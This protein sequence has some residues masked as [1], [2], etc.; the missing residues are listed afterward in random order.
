[1]GNVTYYE[2]LQSGEFSDVTIICR[3]HTWKAHRMVLSA[4]SLWFKKACSGHF[5][6]A[7]ER[8]IT[9][10][11]D[12]PELI[13]SMIKFIYTGERHFE[14][15]SFLDYFEM[16]RLGDY[17]SIDALVQ[18][19]IRGVKEDMDARAQ[20]FKIL[21]AK[22]AEWAIMSGEITEQF[23]RQFINKADRFV[24]L[25]QVSFPFFEANSAD[26]FLQTLLGVCQTHAS[27]LG[28]NEQFRLMLSNEE[29]MGGFARQFFLTL[30]DR[31]ASSDLWMA[32][33][34]MCSAC[35]KTYS[36]DPFGDIS[37]ICEGWD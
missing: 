15:D 6:E 4:Q 23:R 32:E 17:Y 5:K 34:T 31:Q 10:E 13:R 3:D 7:K 14:D 26:P 21:R 30:W 29:S 36:V 9:I 11:D 18:H 1:M 19:A 20:Y 35:K 12:K 28:G 22:Y 27:L 25:L 2:Y 16:Y 24:A 33:L 8:I 37:C